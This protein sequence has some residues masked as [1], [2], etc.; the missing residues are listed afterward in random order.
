MKRNEKNQ[1]K[2]KKHPPKKNKQTE[3][4]YFREAKYISLPINHLACDHMIVNNQ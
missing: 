1:Q 3:A 4:Q 2:N